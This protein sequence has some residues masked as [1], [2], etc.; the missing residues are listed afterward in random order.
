MIFPTITDRDEWNYLDT[1]QDSDIIGFP[2]S[3]DEGYYVRI[4]RYK[5][6][7]CQEVRL[8]ATTFQVLQ[9]GISA[10]P[11]TFTEQQYARQQLHDDLA[12]HTQGD[13][14]KNDW[15]HIL[16]DENLRPSPHF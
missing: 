11:V 12:F 15:L 7:Q 4:L 6:P 16:A 14:T 9:S 8:T 2:F 10:I 3:A 13:I 5:Y 1:L